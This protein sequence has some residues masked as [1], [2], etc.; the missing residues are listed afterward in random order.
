MEAPLSV[1]LP[2]VLISAYSVGLR[3]R[4]RYCDALS[5]GRT[6]EQALARALEG[7][8]EASLDYILTKWAVDQDVVEAAF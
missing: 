5:K 3:G 7:E 6:H 2:E 1:A 8:S 4:Q